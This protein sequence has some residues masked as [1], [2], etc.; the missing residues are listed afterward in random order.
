M[1]PGL[2]V[3][4]HAVLAVFACALGSFIALHHPL[5]PLPL[6]VTF[7]AWSTAVF[8]RPAIWPLVLPALLP[9][10]GLAPWTGWIV[11]EEFDLLA[12]GAALGCHARL[13]L[14][15]SPPE[16]QAVAGVVPWRQSR[17]R[18]ARWFALA[19]IGLGLL[20]A[21]WLLALVR[22]LMA[23]SAGAGPDSVPPGWFAAYED[24]LNSLRTGKS[25]LLILLLLP[26]LRSL[27]DGAPELLARR[28][29]AGV[30]TGL[31]LASLAILVERAGYPGLLDFSTAYRS[32]A[33]FWEMHVGGAA[34]D[35]FL[36]MAVPFAVHAVLRAPGP[37]AWVLAAALALIAA[38]AGLTSFSRGVYLSVGSSLT[39]LAGLLCSTAAGASPPA[40][41]AVVRPSER[42]RV[43]GGRVLVGVL[44]CELVAVLALGDF[45]GRRLSASAR[46]LG[47]RLQHWS[48]GLSLLRSPAEVLFGRGLGRFPANYSQA[49]PGREMPGRLRVIDLPGQA[50]GSYLRLFGPRH[51][52]HLRGAFDLLQRVPALAEGPYT[53]V[54]E[55]RAARLAR[56]RVE[57]CQ[58]H[59]LYAVPCGRSGVLVHQGGEQWQQVS[60]GLRSNKQTGGWWRQAGPGFISLQ[61]AGPADY[62]DIGKVSVLAADGRELLRN[63]AFSDGLRHWFFA[64]HD[65]FVPW[66]IDNLFLELLIDQGA[67]GLL[68][69]L[70]LLVLAFAN[71]LGGPG[72]AQTLAPYLLASLLAAVVVGMVS[73]LLDMPRTAFLFFLL[74]CFALFLD[75]EPAADPPRTPVCPPEKAI[76]DLAQSKITA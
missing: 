3:A 21:S 6:T 27:L 75:E 36:A 60:L 65:Y 28:L 29:A 9:V 1:S 71:L 48:E 37:L 47:G 4:L 56:L 53:V 68:L 50:Q 58:R 13:V 57:L 59:L 70:G 26:S 54:L 23:A 62:I 61:F 17:P 31:A 5:W 52:E 15:R 7:L 42:W 35:A 73:S 32:T 39:V 69:L 30:A 51:N 25:L 38:Y 8:L 55:L 67:I 10:A 22:G 43:W 14:R 2:Q 19:R 33:L 64:G 18:R 16:D 44:I 34:L 40:Q 41:A 72:R 76:A 63:A 20:A 46:D 12:L 66:H 24:P 45:M 74:L 49:V 11:V